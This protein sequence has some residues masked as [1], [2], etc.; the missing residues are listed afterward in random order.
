MQ[1]SEHPCAIIATTPQFSGFGPSFVGC[2]LRLRFQRHEFAAPDH[3]PWGVATMFFKSR[4]SRRLKSFRS[5][6]SALTQ[7]ELVEPRLLLSADVE[8]ETV[9]TGTGTGQAEVE[10]KADNKEQ[11]LKIDIYNVP[12]ATYTVFVGQT[13]LGD[14][15][16]GS[17]RII[18][19]EFTS[20][21]GSG[22]NRSLPWG[23]PSKREPK[24]ASFPQPTFP[25]SKATLPSKAKIHRFH[26]AF[27][28]TSPLPTGR[29]W[30]PS[31]KPKPKAANWKS[32]SG[33]CPPNPSINSPLVA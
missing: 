3:P 20:K 17:S 33:I 29:C 4:N 31:T 10:Y 6:N 32:P 2:D 7:V 24:F 23:L 21:A 8:L 5:N 25:R 18:E 27:D 9:L 30:S 13:S 26:H 1:T 28:S 19:V 22:S 15:T 12:P 11:S 16:V 14:L